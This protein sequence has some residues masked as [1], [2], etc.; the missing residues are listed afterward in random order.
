MTHKASISFED[1]NYQFLNQVA[2][3]NRSA[4]INDL[5]T[6]ERLKTLERAILAA[7]EEESDPEYQQELSLWEIT[8]ND[9]L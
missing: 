5:L 4:Y 2:V 1:Q 7:N 6:R 8:S 9:G 3:K